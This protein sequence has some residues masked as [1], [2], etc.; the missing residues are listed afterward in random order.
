MGIAVL[1]AIMIVAGFSMLVSLFY[2]HSL[3]LNPENARSLFE[4]I[5][6]IDGVLLGFAAVLF[7]VIT[8][9]I[10]LK[11]GLLLV[12]AIVPSVLFYLFSIWI[13]F[14][15]IAAAA[16]SGTSFV[17]PIV[18]QIV[19]TAFLFCTFALVAAGSEPSF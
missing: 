12:V 19:A 2:F 16:T 11:V 10:K 13:S 18:A 15:G 5:V 8:T 3:T 14:L 17:L 9:R 4:K 1:V 7:G 6:D